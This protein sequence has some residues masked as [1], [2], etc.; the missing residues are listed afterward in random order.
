M[1]VVGAGGVTLYK[2]LGGTQTAVVA[3]PADSAMVAPPPSVPVPPQSAGAAI[4]NI[5]PKEVVPA[6]SAPATS[7][8]TPLSPPPSTGRGG[9][10]NGGKNAL[11]PPLPKPIETKTTTNITAPVEPKV[12]TKPK[13]EPTKVANPGF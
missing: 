1:L 6:A 8:A 7:V 3:A 12:E 10:R 13:T 5:D 9:K 11:P 4:A 2:T